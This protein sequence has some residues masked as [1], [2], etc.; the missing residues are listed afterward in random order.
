MTAQQSVIVC[1]AGEGS[2]SD[3][4]LFVVSVHTYPATN[5]QLA[6]IMQEKLP[7]L[8]AVRHR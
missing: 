1:G 4:S 8:V 7:P 5:R 6:Q 2:E 3:V